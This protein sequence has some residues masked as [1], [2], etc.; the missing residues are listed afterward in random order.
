[1]QFTACGLPVG[2]TTGSPRHR[3]PGSRFLIYIVP[4]LGVST[5]LV[6]PHHVCSAVAVDIHKPQVG[7][8]FVFRLFYLTWNDLLTGESEQRWIAEND[9]PMS[10]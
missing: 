5:V 10:L 6:Q 3:A 7:S 2:V 8:L 9:L 4:D 1:M